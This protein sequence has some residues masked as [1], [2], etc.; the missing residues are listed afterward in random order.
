MR[1]RTC[2]HGDDRAFGD[3]VNDDVGS[4]DDV[5]NDDV[6]S[7]VSKASIF[8]FRK[9]GGAWAYGLRGAAG[10]GFGVCIEFIPAGGA[11]AEVGTGCG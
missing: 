2:D 11:A 7:G 8:L 9:P 10:R 1:H 3:V 6:G 4:D 5:A